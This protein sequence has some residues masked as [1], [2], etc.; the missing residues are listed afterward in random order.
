MNNTQDNFNILREINNNPKASQRKLAKRLGYSL[1]KLNYCLKAMKNRGFIYILKVYPN[2][3]RNPNDTEN[4]KKFGI[5]YLLTSKGLSEKK[6]LAFHF[7][8]KKMREYD[9]L[10][11]EIEKD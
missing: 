6:Q 10:K 11:L 9:E 5:S 4:P 7:M 2:S 8:K 3:I 1:G